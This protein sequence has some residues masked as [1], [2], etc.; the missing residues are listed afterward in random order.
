MNCCLQ[1]F[2]GTTHRWGERLISK[3]P[4]GDFSKF[5]NVLTH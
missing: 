2:D 4:R 3:D 5:V 1:H